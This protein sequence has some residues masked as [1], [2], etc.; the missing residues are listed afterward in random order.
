MSETVNL[1]EAQQQ[2]QAKMAAMREELK[3]L[4]ERLFREGAQ[5]IFD[6]YPNLVSFSWTQYT[7]YFND[8]DECVFSVH[9]EYGTTLKFE[10]ESDDEDEEDDGETF[11]SY[12][13]KYA[14]PSVELPSYYADVPRWKFNVGGDVASLIGG[15]DDDTMKALFG[16]HVRVTVTREGID[17]EYHEHD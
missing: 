3:S 1:K 5:D 17:T 13:A 7:P 16:D 15:V 6:A 14:D 10:G 11:S 12:N 9:A 4:G 8:G 2:I